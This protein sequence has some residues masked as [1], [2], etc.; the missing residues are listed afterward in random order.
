[1]Q[2][3]LYAV[4][5][6]KRKGTSVCKC[7]YV[8]KLLTNNT[9]MESQA[10]AIEPPLEQPFHKGFLRKR[11]AAYDHREIRENVFGEKIQE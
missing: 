11:E 6:K 7:D 5:S 1:M 3:K 10:D 4:F 8:F 2:R 9:Y